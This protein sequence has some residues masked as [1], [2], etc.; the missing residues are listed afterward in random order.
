M[1]VNLFKPKK[2]GVN[3]PRVRS[4]MMSANPSVRSYGQAFAIILL[5][6]GYMKH[7]IAEQSRNNPSVA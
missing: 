5:D 1:I 4:W 6:K 7:G 2:A 3:G